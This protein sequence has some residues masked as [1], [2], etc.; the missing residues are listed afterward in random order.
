[1]LPKEEFRTTSAITTVNEG[2]GEVKKYPVQRSKISDSYR[3]PSVKA[4]A[5][6]SRWTIETA[7]ARWVSR[8][9][10]GNLKNIHD[11]RMKAQAPN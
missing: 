7:R 10:E 8:E 9:N 3:L 11:V 4:M 6:Y 5:K 1:M 2:Q